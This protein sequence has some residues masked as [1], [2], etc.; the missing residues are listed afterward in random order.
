M[1]KLWLEAKNW[2]RSS[3]RGE[4]LG[5]QV[6][7]GLYLLRGYIRAKCLNRLPDLLNMFTNWT[8]PKISGGTQAVK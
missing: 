3:I 8:T 7:S 1:V 4:V 5:F 2:Q 6:V